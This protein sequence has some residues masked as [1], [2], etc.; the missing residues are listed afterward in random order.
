MGT[1][2]FSLTQT[3]FGICCRSTSNPG[4]PDSIGS[5]SVRWI[6]QTCLRAPTRS[7]WTHQGAQP[8]C[9]LGCLAGFWNSLWCGWRYHTALPLILTPKIDS[10]IWYNQE[11]LSSRVRGFIWFYIDLRIP[12]SGYTLQRCCLHTWCKTLVPQLD[13]ICALMYPLAVRNSTMTPF[14]VRPH[15]NA[16]SQV[17]G[18]THLEYCVI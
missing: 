1:S 16:R 13:D 17:H 4:D 3:G 7:K 14:S 8:T 11:T 15:W 6:S 10:S 2:K 9:L 5:L 12:L 18:I